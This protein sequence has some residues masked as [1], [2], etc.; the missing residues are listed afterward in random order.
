MSA[1][2]TP[3]LLRRGPL[4]GRIQALTRYTRDG[5]TTDGKEIL[6]AATDGKHDVTADFDALICELL[7]DPDSPDIIAILDGVA[8]NLPLDDAEREQAR[9]FRERLAALI[10][11]HNATGHAARITGETA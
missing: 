9:A 1:R 2:K 7:L 4:S 8:R 10:E 3:V 5:R 6:K 11:R